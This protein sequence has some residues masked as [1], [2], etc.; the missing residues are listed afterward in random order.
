[1]KTETQPITTKKKK[2]K[3][4]SKK[5]KTKKLIPFTIFPLI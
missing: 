1:M 5:K 3:E 2:R 4:N